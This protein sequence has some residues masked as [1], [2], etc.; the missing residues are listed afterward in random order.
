VQRDTYEVVAFDFEDSFP[1]FEVGRPHCIVLHTDG[2]PS[3]HSALDSLTWGRRE[4]AF[5]C[6]YYIEAD[7]VVYSAVDPTHL[8]FHVKEHRRAAEWGW[9]ITH[10]KVSGRRG[11]IGAIGIEHVQD[12]DAHW[13][14]ETRISSLLLVRDLMTR[15]PELAI[16]EHGDLDPWQRANDVGDAL[17][18]ADFRADLRD[19]REGRTPW[20]TVDVLATG[21]R[22]PGPAPAPPSVDLASIAETEIRQAARI[23][24]LEDRLNTL[25]S[26]HAA[27]QRA[28]AEWVQSFS[29]DA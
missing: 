2:N 14:Q 26:A 6:H 5:S 22:H 17:N 20:R 28:L 12:A 19:M 7:G 24:L 23:T 27:S 4:R 25:E 8:A 18:L 10:R 3:P 29:V 21:Q 13:S 1:T 9:P 15:W 11:D 16:V